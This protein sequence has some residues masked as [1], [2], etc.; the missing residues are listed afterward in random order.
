MK[1]LFR[2]IQR[3]TFPRPFLGPRQAIAG[4]LLLLLVFFSARFTAIKAREYVDQKADDAALW[5]LQEQTVTRGFG[6]QL[7]D[8][9]L[10]FAASFGLGLADAMIRFENIPYNP[11]GAFISLWKGMNPGILVEKVE[12]LNHAV[13]LTI[14]CENA[15][16]LVAYRRSLLRESTFS[17]IQVSVSSYSADEPIQATVICIFA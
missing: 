5:I 7:I 13:S 2:A 9:Q 14:S 3:G 6:L 16:F 4:L 10:R 1:R 15:K 11:Q 17:Q 8:N 12:F